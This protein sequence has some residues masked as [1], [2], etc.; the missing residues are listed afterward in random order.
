M[1]WNLKMCTTLNK[2][3]ELPQELRQ[4]QPKLSKLLLIGFVKSDTDNI[5]R[6]KSY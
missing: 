4:E 5:T 3:T 2:N 1:L 6:T